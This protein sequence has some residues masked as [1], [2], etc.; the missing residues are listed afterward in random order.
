MKMNQ[1][2]YSARVARIYL[3]QKMTHLKDASMQ[4]RFY[5]VKQAKSVNHRAKASECL[6]R[7][8]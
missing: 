1:N 5:G 3:N 2:Q 7:T 4:T 8:K 6:R